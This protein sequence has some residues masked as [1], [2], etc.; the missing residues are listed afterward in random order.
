MQRYYIPGQLMQRTRAA[1]GPNA[2]IN[3]GKFCIT[4]HSCREGEAKR[5]K[6]AV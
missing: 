5:R 6:V 2:S 3:T 1:T 4:D